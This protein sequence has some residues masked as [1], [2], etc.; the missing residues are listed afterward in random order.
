M[1]EATTLIGSFR[2]DIHARGGLG[3]DNGRAPDVVDAPG[4]GEE[5]ENAEDGHFDAEEEA[6]NADLDVG[7]LYAMGGFDGSGRGEEGY[8]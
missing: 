1:A 7:G 8:Y 3:G 5:V 4:E 6:R 2:V